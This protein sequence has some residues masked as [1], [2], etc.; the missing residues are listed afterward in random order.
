M[1]AAKVGGTVRRARDE[2]A[3]N[4]WDY[5]PFA[6]PVFRSIPSLRGVGAVRA[7]YLG[8]GRLLVRWD[9]VQLRSV[10][11]FRVG[12]ADSADLRVAF[13]PISSVDRPR[14]PRVRRKRWLVHDPAPSAARR[15]ESK[16]G[17]AH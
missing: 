2:S 6:A 12:R 5:R 4:V 15:F 11:R 1:Q 14:G 8:R 3:K 10:W 9:M 13:A 16:I 17:R 7:D